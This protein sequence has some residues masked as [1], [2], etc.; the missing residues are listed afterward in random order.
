M[1]L[2]QWLKSLWIK[3]RNKRK[4]NVAASALDQRDDEYITFPWS[5]PLPS[6]AFVIPRATFVKDQGSIGW[7]GSFAFVKAIEIIMERDN[8]AWDIDLSE[9]FHY[10]EVR[11]RN[12]TY[13]EDKGQELRDG[14]KVLRK[15]GVAPEVLCKTDPLM[16]NVKPSQFS[17]DYA[18]YWNNFGYSRCYSVSAIKEHLAT[19]NPVVFGMKV[20][21]EFLVER[22]QDVNNAGSSAGGHALCAI[23]YD[24]EH[25]N[26]DGTKGAIFFVNSWGERWGDKGHAWIGYDLLNKHFIEAWAVKSPSI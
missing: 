24:D 23:G 22:D 3:F 1:S 9:R 13:P 14:A 17:Y 19:G 21:W 11:Q 25:S 6:A 2:S 5:K 10:Y 26:P 8:S 16:F 7:C 15:I 18:K 12:G 20:N 4:L